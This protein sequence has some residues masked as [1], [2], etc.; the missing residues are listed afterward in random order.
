M[1]KYNVR[2]GG[3]RD[4]CGRVC[5]DPS[6]MALESM[7]GTVQTLELV[8]VIDRHSE[9]CDRNQHMSP[10]IG[11]SKNLEKHTNPTSNGLL[12]FLLWFFFFLYPCGLTTS[13][14]T[15]TDPKVSCAEQCVH[16]QKEPR[17]TSERHT[18]GKLSI[19][20]VK[21]RNPNF[22]LLLNWEF[23]Y[24]IYSGFCFCQD[25]NWKMCLHYASYWLY[26][27]RL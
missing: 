15:D 5:C 23:S 25:F 4:A 8:G 19:F 10:N 12:L 14:V 6:N 21:Y 1:K 3:A 22:I 24:Y 20:K 2:W 18:Y 7:L 17:N 27:Y 26:F 9:D 11:I 16:M 13:V